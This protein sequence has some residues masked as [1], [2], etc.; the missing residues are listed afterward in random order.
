MQE[1][2]TKWNTEGACSEGPRATWRRAQPWVQVRPERVFPGQVQSRCLTAEPPFTEEAGWG[3]ALLGLTE[4]S[5]SSQGC[6]FSV[7]TVV[8]EEK[9][10]VM[11]KESVLILIKTHICSVTLGKA[12]PRSTSTFSQ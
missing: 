8:L 9:E 6:N 11:A 4:S 10:G 5:A 1:N 12:S 2:E 7:K 3:R